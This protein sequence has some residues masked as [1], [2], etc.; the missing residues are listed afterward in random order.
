MCELRTQFSELCTS[1]EI[2][3]SAPVLFIVNSSL[4]QSSSADFSYII[5]EFSFLIADF[6]VSS[7][8]TIASY[9]WYLCPLLT[10]PVLSLIYRFFI[11]DLSFLIT[12]FSFLSQTH[13]FLS[14][15]YRFLSL[16]SFLIANSSYHIADLSY[17]DA[18]KPF[19]K[20]WTLLFLSYE[21]GLHCASVHI[22]WPMGSLCRCLW[23]RID[24]CPA[25]VS[26][27][28]D[29]RAS[30]RVASLASLPSGSC[31]RV[32]W[33]GDLGGQ[34]VGWA[35]LSYPRALLSRTHGPGFTWRRYVGAE[36][37]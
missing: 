16:T 22:H 1:F 36:P 31:P 20:S 37:E 7:R 28:L 19:L 4:F 34:G 6:F 25:A 17:C 26:P 14:L 18:H 12:N 29:R 5:A 15:T 27:N 3:A 30:S 10:C 21:G 8:W 23:C 33:W 11:A 35:Y 32:W 2:W 24:V 13:R 9:R